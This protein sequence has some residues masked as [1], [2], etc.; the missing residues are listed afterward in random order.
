MKKMS[1]LPELHIHCTYHFIITN[2]LD[3]IDILS[4]FHGQRGQQTEQRDLHKDK[5]SLATHII[6]F[7]KTKIKDILFAT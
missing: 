3:L 2:Y 4:L 7:V 1:K 5:Y 6:E